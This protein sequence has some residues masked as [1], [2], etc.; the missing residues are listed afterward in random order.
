[1]I[2]SNYN[3]FTKFLKAQLSNP[4]TFKGRIGRVEYLL[5]VIF[6]TLLTFPVLF[7]DSPG[8]DF[9]NE[10]QLDFYVVLFVFLVC[11]VLFY[12]HA[13]VIKRL[14]DA[15]FSGWWSI[16]IIWL[17]PILL[18]VVIKSESLLL[19]FLI[20]RLSY[21]ILLVIKGTKG[22]NKYGGPPEF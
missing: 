1:M 13:F 12:T 5:S 21:T 19:T 10:N 20:S 3:L 9:S 14:H 7:I 8:V 15:D 18:D 17:L 16:V 2:F 11:F 6:V 22:K 4:F